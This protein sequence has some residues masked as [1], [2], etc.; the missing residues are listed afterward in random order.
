MKFDQT[1]NNQDNVN[2]VIDSI[3]D[4]I[5]LTKEECKELYSLIDSLSGCNAGNVF[6]WD[7]TDDPNDPGISACVKVFRMVGA[8]IPDNCKGVIK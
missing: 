2:N 3:T 4:V 5:I 6:A 1:N 7:G 8:R